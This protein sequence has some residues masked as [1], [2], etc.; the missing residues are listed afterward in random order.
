MYE[1]CRDCKYGNCYNEDWCGCYHPVL[2]GA[3]VQIKIYCAVEL[4]TGKEVKKND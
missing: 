4:L 1:P 2:K 3:N